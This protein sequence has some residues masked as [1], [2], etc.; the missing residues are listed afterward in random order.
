ML[1]GTNGGGLPL[2]CSPDK[3]GCVTAWSREGAGHMC[4]AGRFQRQTLPLGKPPERNSF[5]VS[6]IFE[7][8]S[9][10]R[11]HTIPSSI[12]RLLLRWYVQQ[13][14]ALS[15]LLLSYPATAL[16]DAATT[17]VYVAAHNRMCQYQLN[18]LTGVLTPL[19]P[20]CV[21]VGKG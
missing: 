19:S 21:T 20:P 5:N 3:E 1:T 8:E 2:P 7:K 12:V 15:L 4:N 17:F 10:M 14:V 9:A 13:W 16:A 6:T 11:S 18:L